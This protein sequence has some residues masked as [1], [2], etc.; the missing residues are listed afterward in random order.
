MSHPAWIHAAPFCAATVYSGSNE[1][2][3]ILMIFL[4]SVNPKVTYTR[5]HLKFFF[6]DSPQKRSFF[7]CTEP[8][9]AAVYNLYL[10]LFFFPFCD[11]G[12]VRNY[13]HYNRSQLTSFLPGNPEPRQGY[14]RL[15]F[16]GHGSCWRLGLQSHTHTHA[17]THIKMEDYVFSY[18]AAKHSGI[19]H[20]KFTTNFPLSHNAR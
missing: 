1:S 16:L 6:L 11:E 13:Q 9:S 7:F 8:E 10:L 4:L 2:V 20:V 14:R 5:T 12:K 15:E 17:N 19:S 3:R 18:E